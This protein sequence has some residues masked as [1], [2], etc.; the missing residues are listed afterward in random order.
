MVEI[1]LVSLDCIKEPLIRIFVRLQIANLHCSSKSTKEDLLGSEVNKVCY[2]V[3]RVHEKVIVNSGE[4]N[5]SDGQGCIDYAN[6][7]PS[8]TKLP[9]EEVGSLGS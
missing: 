9:I 1:T 5:C 7:V 4:E 3:K 2:L 6:N 8:T